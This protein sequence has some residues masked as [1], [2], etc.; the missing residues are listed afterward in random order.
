MPCLTTLYNIVSEVLAIA[1]IQENAINGTQI[2]KKEI[3]M[4]LFSD[5]MI[6]YRKSQRINKILLELVNNYS[7]VSG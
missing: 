4:S 1:K 6:V 7:N 3:K 5:I 2:E